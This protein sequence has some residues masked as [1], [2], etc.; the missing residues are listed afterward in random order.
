MC[1]ASALKGLG[2]CW[3]GGAFRR[4]RFAKAAKLGKGERLAI[5]I[6]LGL[7]SPG[8]REGALRRRI[9]GGTRKGW[10]EILV[11]GPGPEPSWA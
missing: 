7:E 11:G 5:V 3:L 6:A 4:G 2:S 10:E 8:A 9:G 1:F